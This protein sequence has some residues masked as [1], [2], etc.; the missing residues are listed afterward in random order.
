MSLIHFGCVFLWTVYLDGMGSKED[1]YNKVYESV[2][3]S[4]LNKL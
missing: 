4:M 2:Q 3:N 1:I